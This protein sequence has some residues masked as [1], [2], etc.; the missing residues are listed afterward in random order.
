M[1]EPPSLIAPAKAPH[2]SSDHE[3]TRR[4][5]LRRAFW[6]AGGAAAAVAVAGVTR[7]AAVPQPPYTVDA[8]QIPSPGGEPRVF[9]DGKFYLVNLRPGDGGTVSVAPSESG[10]LL[11]LHWRCP[12][13]GIPLRWRSDVGFAGVRQWIDR[14][15]VPP[16]NGWF[17]CLRCDS[18]FTR[19][20][21]R[22]YGPS[23]SMIS[24]LPIRLRF[25][26]APQVEVVDYQPGPSSDDLRRHPSVDG[27]QHPLTV[28]TI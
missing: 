9:P 17:R 2:K 1:M 3:P 26:G 12:N 25:G 6:L 23:P 10:G 22:V 14:F 7:F 28:K 21:I 13:D 18:T 5:L 4:T 8:G 20:G 15:V 19:A 24:P 27:T 16:D 11:A